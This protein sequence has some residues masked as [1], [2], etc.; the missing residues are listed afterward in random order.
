MHWLSSPTVRWDRGFFRKLLV[1]CLPI[2]I[3][4]LMSA[5]LH[6]IDGVMIGQL[7]DAPYAAVTQ[8]TRYVFVYQLF[9]FGLASGCGI[10]FSQH[11][12]TQDVKSMRRAMGLCFRGA[13]VLAVLFGG[14]GLL[15]PQGVMSIFLPK[16]ESFGYAIQYLTIVAAGFLITA[17]DTV[18]ATC[19][20]SA[21]KTVIP[22]TAGICSILTNTFLNWILIYGNLGAPALGRARGGH[23][24]GDCRGGVP[25]HQCELLLWDEAAL[26]LPLAGLEAA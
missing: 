23:C 1:V 8:A 13:L 20:K 7:G 6:I 15:F 26:R 25:G 14:L 4:N 10:F 2:V 18:Y 11:W 12:G 5:S 19:M 21:G 17:V 22:M 24:H 9:L 3:Q 16:G